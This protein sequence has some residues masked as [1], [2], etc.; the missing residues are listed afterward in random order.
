[1]R[2]A[3]EKYG[4]AVMKEGEVLLFVDAALE[5]GSSVG[6][7][8]SDMRMIDTL[9][10]AER[11]HAVCGPMTRKTRAGY[12]RRGGEFWRMMDGILEGRL[13]GEF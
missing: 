9:L 13:R 11:L 3:C 2:V 4:T 10:Y 8:I 12:Y 5:N 7:A 6:E 1:M